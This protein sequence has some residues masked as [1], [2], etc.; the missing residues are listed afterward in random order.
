MSPEDPFDPERLRLDRTVF[1]ASTAAP[2]G[3]RKPPRHRPGQWFLRGPVPWPWVEAAARLP[4]RVMTLSWC[5]W[6]EA[7]R[8]R[9]RTFR[10]CLSRVGLG[11]NLYAAR[12]AL[13]S[14]EAAGL[15]AVRRQ[16]G[17]GLEV[18]LLDAPTEEGKR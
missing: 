8:H 11:M 7:G 12:R 2:P 4:G 5:L 3:R 9:Q 16:P 6:R 14:L 13:R 17:C 1:P 10:L 18:T 15:V